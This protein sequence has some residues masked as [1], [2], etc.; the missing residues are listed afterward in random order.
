LAERYLYSVH[1]L[2]HLLFTL[3]AAPLVLLGTPAWLARRLLSPKWLLGVVR[4]LSR[5]VV[6][7]IQFNVVIVVSHWPAVVELTVRHHPLHFIAH[8][9]LL[10]SA[11]LMWMPVLSPLPEVPRAKPLAQMLYLFLQTVVP[12]VP[13]SFLTFGKTPLY[14]IYATFPRLWDIPALDDQQAAGLIMKLGGGLLLWTV[15][16]IIFFRWY[17][18]EERRDRADRADTADEVAGTKDVLL[19]SDVERELSQLDHGRSDK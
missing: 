17:A 14:H 7:L 16:A 8:A 11:L 19:W 13:A 15:I 12:T 4:G 1:M 3:G 2:Q 6:G 5:P 18:A 9:V 10:L